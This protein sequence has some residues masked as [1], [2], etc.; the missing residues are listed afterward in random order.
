M[1][2]LIC[3]HIS[4]TTRGRDRGGRYYWDVIAQGEKIGKWGF[5][6]KLDFNPMPVFFMH[7][8]MWRVM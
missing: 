8:A 2:K 5:S 6:N 1:Q 3:V 4:L 7:N